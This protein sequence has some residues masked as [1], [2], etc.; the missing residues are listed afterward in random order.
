MFYFRFITCLLTVVFFP[1]F[2]DEDDTK[3]DVKAS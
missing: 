3:K 1:Y 2:I